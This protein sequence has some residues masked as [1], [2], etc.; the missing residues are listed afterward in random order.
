MRRILLVI[1]AFAVAL[2]CNTVLSDEMEMTIVELPQPDTDSDFSLERAISERR[3]VREFTAE[4]VTLRQVSQML[5]ACQ[6]VTSKDGL[7]SAP[8]AGALYPL[9]VFVV[10]N[11]V[12]GLDQGIYQYLPGTNKHALKL[13]RSGDFLSDLASAALGQ[14]CIRGCA[15]GIVISAVYQRTTVKYG[16]RAE[17]YVL[18][19]TGHAAQNLCLQ[20]QSLGLGVVTVG[21][22][23]DKNVKNLIDSQADPVYIICVGAT[24]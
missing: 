17:R 18:I 6:G 7:R 13:L 24:Q 14:D 2:F 21:A 16:T 22:F 12:Q 1:L 20:A 3:S 8:S 5:W 19:E 10:A 4:P 9:E 23:N 15:V 11:K